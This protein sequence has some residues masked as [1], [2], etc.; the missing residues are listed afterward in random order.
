[1]QNKNGYEM[2]LETVPFCPIQDSFLD[3]SGGGHRRG[4]GTGTNCSLDVAIKAPSALCADL[5]QPKRSTRYPGA[6][7]E[8]F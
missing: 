8:A 3:I 7:G 1:M 4:A 6:G 2:I 5:L